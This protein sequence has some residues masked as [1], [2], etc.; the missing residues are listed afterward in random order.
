M[1]S[2]DRIAL[3]RFYLSDHLGSVLATVNSDGKVKSRNLYRP[4]G[5]MLNSMVSGSQVNHFR[6]TGQ[7]LDE[8]LSRDL[9]Y[10]GQ[11][12]YDSKL[13]VFTSV[14]PKGYLDPGTGSYI[15]CRNNPVKYVDPQGEVFDT[16]LDI[17]SIAYD[18]VDIVSSIARGQGTTGTQWAALGADV[19]GALIPFVTGAGM[20]VR[21][22]AKADD[23]VD[24][25][26]ALSNVDDAADAAKATDKVA[27]A[28]KRIHGNSLD[29]PKE[30][31]LYQL[32]DS[33]TGEHLKYGVTGASPVESRYSK[34]FM[35]TKE[36]TPIASGAR[37]DMVKVER[38]L[39]EKNPGPLNKEPWAGKS[40]E[41]Q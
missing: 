22:G 8:D 12:Y 16:F 32:S 19:G 33:K 5:E 23:L 25:G 41:K 3:Y 17:G 28:G 13:R 1:T 7:F 27:D 40:V 30:A 21:A 10:Y 14:D 6:Y 4:W 9:M 2:Q 35:S 20:A 39:V 18:V 36:M 34:E 37:K 38:G 15:Y 26:K 24:A 31:T 29:S 11:R